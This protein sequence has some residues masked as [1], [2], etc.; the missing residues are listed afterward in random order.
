MAGCG[1]RRILALILITVT[2][3]LYVDFFLGSGGLTRR[4]DVEQI[5]EPRFLN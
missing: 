3:R 2:A 5:L 4:P 1:F